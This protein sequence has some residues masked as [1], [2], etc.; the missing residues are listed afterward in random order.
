MHVAPIGLLAVFAP[1]QTAGLAAHAA[2]LT[3]GHP[4]GY[5]SAAASAAMV[6]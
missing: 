5:I 2:A 4:S 3:H 1:A 6:R